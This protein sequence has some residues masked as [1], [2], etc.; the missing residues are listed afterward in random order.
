M[1]VCPAEQPPL[2]EIGGGRRVA[3]H[4]ADDFAFPP[5]V[6]PAGGDGTSALTPVAGDGPADPAGPAKAD[7]P[8]LGRT[9]KEALFGTRSRARLVP[10]AMIDRPRDDQGTGGTQR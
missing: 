9:M 2:R 1:D 7:A 6:R 8:P 4:L 5:I 10:G 3:C